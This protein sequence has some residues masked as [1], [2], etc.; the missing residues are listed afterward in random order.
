MHVKED[1][2]AEKPNHSDVRGREEEQGGDP[3]LT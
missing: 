2:E 3:I 1:G